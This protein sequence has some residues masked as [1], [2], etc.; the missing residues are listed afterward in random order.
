MP[1]VVIAVGVPGVGKSTVLSIASRK[2]TERGYVVR[3]VNFGD[4]MLEYLRRSGAVRSRDEIRGLRLSTQSEAQE[5]AAKNIR[6]DLDA[7]TGGRVIG[8]V[9]THAVIRTQSGY[10]PGLPPA[11]LRELRPDIIVVIEASPD[12][13]ISRQH[14]DSN[15]F[16]ADLSS[17]ET[18]EELL[19][20]NRYYAAAYSALSGAALRFIKN[21][22][23]LAE[24]AAEELVK[25]VE[26]I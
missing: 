3:L 19:Q 23:G 2:L 7:L 9:D 16:R 26:E 12:E 17:R 15:R 5:V 13:I 20:I 11:V 22:E 24:R 10:W 18:I 21:S 6:R 14:R 1:K 4:Y 25:A 8:I